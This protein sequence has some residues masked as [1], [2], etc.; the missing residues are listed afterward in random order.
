MKVL[1][2]RQPW[3]SLIVHGVKHIE[4]RTRPVNIRGR[5]GIL[6][7]LHRPKDLETW[8]DWQ[9]AASV[10]R[11]I[12]S[13]PALQH[14][15]S[16]MPGAPDDLPVEFGAL[17][18]TVELYDCVPIV[19]YDEKPVDASPMVS[20]DADDRGPMVELWDGD[21]WHE[22]DQYPYGEFAPGRWAWLLRDP[23]PLA[24]PIP[25]RGALGWQEVEIP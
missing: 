20:I 4:T 11:P 15:A 18:G 13:S 8:G 3:A 14:H 6:A 9:Y 25:M 2:V 1:T 19:G 10:D 5:I 23:Q 12:V 22:L 17:I 24:E 21:D 7:G 16:G